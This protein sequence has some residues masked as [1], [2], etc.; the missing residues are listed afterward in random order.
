[1]NEFG[2][3][4][5]DLT[6]L[7]MRLEGMFDSTQAKP[8]KA[9]LQRAFIEACKASRAQ[10]LEDES[11]AQAPQAPHANAPSRRKGSAIGAL[12]QKKSAVTQMR[13]AQLSA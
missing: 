7:E 11:S 6:S 5:D 10:R 1:M 13:S 9:A 8:L 3:I 4:A 12:S 2:R